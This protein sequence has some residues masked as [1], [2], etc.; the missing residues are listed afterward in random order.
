MLP[1]AVLTGLAAPFIGGGI[2]Y[3]HQPTT[4]TNSTANPVSTTTATLNGS[5]TS[6]STH[7]YDMSFCYST[8]SS[9]VTTTSCTGSH[10][11]ANPATVSITTA[12]SETLA[13]TGLTANTKY[14]FNIYALDTNDSNT[15]YGT[16]VLSFTTTVA[17]PVVTTNAAT[18]I[19]TTTATLNGSVNTNSDTDTMKFC[20]STTSSQVTSSSCG[21]TLTAASPASASGSAVA[22]TLAVT[23]LT[24]GT[25]Y[26]FNLVATSSGG[27]T[28]YGTS[29]LSFTTD[30]VPVVTT[31]AA[32]AISTTTATLNGSVNPEGDSDI[33]QFCYSTTS[34]QV[35]SSS[36]TGTLTAGSTSPATGSSAVTEPV[37]LSGLTAN[38]TYYFNLEA[39]S[40]GSTIYYGTPTSLTTHAAP[41][42]TVSA[43]N[44]INTT[45]ATLNGSVNPE[46]DSDTVQ[47]CYSTTSSQVTSSSCTG[48]VTTASTSPATGSSAVAETLALTALTPNAEDYFNLVATS[49]GGTNYYGTPANFTT[50]AVAPTV[51]FTGTGVTGSSP[52]FAITTPA[53]SYTASAGA[54]SGGTITYSATG[55][56]GCT[57]GSSTGVVTFTSTASCVITATA[58][59]TG[60]Y[61]S[62]AATLTITPTAVAPTVTWS[63]TGVTGSGSAYTAAGTYGTG[64][65]A[66]ASTNST[67]TISYQVTSGT[68]TYA[69]GMVTFTGLTTCVLTATA[70]QSTFVPPRVWSS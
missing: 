55:Q 26:Y 1:V 17:A 49:S 34:S 39:T 67:G 65:T 6:G 12:T 33:V 19:S 42:I 60:I 32:S 70:V 9:Q 45:T 28:Y 22:E 7:T 68:C 58:A 27:T 36:C 46:G 18:S 35:T 44:P 40:S 5:I 2:A 4:L 30:A 47:F 24:A 43:A 21:G 54:N 25:K 50:N 59:A 63:G 52:S 61:S 11:T 56:P 38:T 29:V 53:S 15:Y 66:S 48:T 13:L 57:V 41:A 69:S 20:Y 3:A 23:G 62:G 64:L 16:N 10:A 37:A 51:S 14:Y 8:S 31:N